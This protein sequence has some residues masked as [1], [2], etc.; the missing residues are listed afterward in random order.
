MRKALL[1]A[2]FVSFVAL[3]GC[4]VPGVLQP[5]TLDK[6]VYFKVDKGS[7]NGHGIQV[8]GDGVTYHSVPCEDGTCQSYGVH[9]H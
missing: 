1:L 2:V 6:A 4:A 5:V 3:Q 7:I 8:T 9:P